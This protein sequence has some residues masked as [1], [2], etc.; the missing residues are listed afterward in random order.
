LVGVKPCLN[1]LAAEDC[2]HMP[3][4]VFED[5]PLA[6]LKKWHYQTI[7]ADPPWSYKTFSKPKEGTVPHRSEVEPYKTMT[8]EE[9]I[10]LPVADLAAKD[11]VLHMWVISSHLD[12]ALELGAAW[13]FTFKSLGLVWVKTCKSDPEMPKMGMG[14]WV[15]QETEIAL[16][17]TRGKPKRTDAGVRQAILEPAREHS[18]KPDESLDRFERLT[19]GPYLEMFSRANRPGWDHMGNQKGKFDSMDPVEEDR[20]AS[21]V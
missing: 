21:L 1:E 17:F 2:P 11:C 18:R 7:A 15:R 19:E 3:G 6:G 9:L 8:R 12:Q 14:K 20:I 4:T 16:I 10:A 5:G 13:G